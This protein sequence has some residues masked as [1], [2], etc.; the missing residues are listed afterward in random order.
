MALKIA[1]WVHGTDAQ[2]EDPGGL[3]PNGVIRE[4]IGTHFFGQSK[5]FNWF[6][7][8][9]P[10]PVVIDDKRPSLV[11]V[12]FFYKLDAG[13]IEHVDIWDG[14][15]RLKEF[16]VKLKGDHLTQI[17]DQNTLLIDP[18]LIVGFGLKLAIGVQFAALFDVEPGTEPAK[19]DF[20]VAAAGADFT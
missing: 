5:S 13:V 3:I 20:L 4:G 9:I 16:N 6:H 10:T 11:K 1:M 8:P 7:V 18:P 17:D 12:F 2:V 15:F 14:P 19:Q